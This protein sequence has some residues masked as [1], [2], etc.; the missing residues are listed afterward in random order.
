MINFEKYKDNRGLITNNSLKNIIDEE[1]ES[2]EKYFL[3]N[4]LN[5]IKGIKTDIKSK[6]TFYANQFK[7][8]DLVC[9]GNDCNNVVNIVNSRLGSFCSKDCKKGSNYL[10]EKG[11][12]QFSDASRY[13][14]TE[15]KLKN[16]YGDNAKYLLNKDLFIQAFLIEENGSNT[17][18][19]TKAKDL[20]NIKKGTLQKYIRKFDLD[21]CS[22]LGN[23][24]TTEQVVQ[25]LLN[26]IQTENKLEIIKNSRKILS[27]KTELDFYLPNYNF[28]IE[29]N[30]VYWH[31]FGGSENKLHQSTRHLKKVNESEEMD[32]HLF[33][34]NENELLDEILRDIW[35]SKIKLKL[36]IYS[37]KYFAR[38]CVIKEINSKIAKEFLES[39]HL[40]GY[41]Y[42]NIKL[43]LFKNDDLLAVMTLGK[44][45]FNTEIE[46]EL[47]RLASK[48][49]TLIVGG[50]SKLLKY[51][52]RNYNPNNIISYGNRRWVNKNNIYDKLGFEF[53]KNTKPNYYYFKSTDWKLQMY[54]RS[55][56]QKHK[57]KD[58]ET[59]KDFYDIDFTEEEIVLNAGYR[60]IWDA[61]HSSYIWT[62][63]NS[64]GN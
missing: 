19:Y 29:T 30:G 23:P 55:L 8:V 16:L 43:G 54:H 46:W 58:L 45:R 49:N 50:A 39:N 37:E 44:P 27:N 17:F 7:K 62:K 2:I 36:G 40:Q 41:A 63:E 24:E 4:Q 9:K 14:Q 52:I 3:D 11:R 21:V 28:A 35:F 25:D 42:S 53:I 38:Q 6:V 1:K 48:K 13:K 10:A 20:L 64:N 18:N 59:T 33:Q 56:F 57:L 51:F 47:I 15:T 5:E 26:E 22:T 12:E 61:G 31:S 60:K 32:I 34:I